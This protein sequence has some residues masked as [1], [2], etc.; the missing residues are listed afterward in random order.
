MLSGDKTVAS[1]LAR[2]HWAL[3]SPFN[4]AFAYVDQTNKLD[5]LPHEHEGFEPWLSSDEL[6]Y[7]S[8][9]NFES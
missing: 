8:P 2:I 9:K 5:V 3:D 1:L 7:A 6:K 4:T